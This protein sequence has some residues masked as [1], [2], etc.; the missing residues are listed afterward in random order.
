MSKISISKKIAWSLILKIN[1]INHPRKDIVIINENISKKNIHFI[2]DR[3]SNTVRDSNIIFNQEITN[4]FDI[5]LPIVCSSK[6]LQ[7]IGHIA[8]SLDGYIAT[9]AGESKYISSKDNLEH[10]HRLRALADIIIV[11]ANTYTEDRPQLTTRLVEGSNPDI[12]IFDPKK[13]LKHDLTT[14]NINI[15]HDFD[16]FKKELDLKKNKIIYVEG[17]GRTISHFMTKNIFDRVH[18]CLCPIILGGGRPS[19]IEDKYININKLKSYQTKHYM[20]GRDILF[21]IKI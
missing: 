1:T 2:Y 3:K 8:Q 12:Y 17:G 16:R 4:L 9:I 14:K 6:K 11:G 5:F 15:I 10:I 19:F 21:D 18:V 7:F 20:M 13:K